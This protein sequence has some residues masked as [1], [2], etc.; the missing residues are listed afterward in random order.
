MAFLSLRIPIHKS[1]CLFAI[2]TE[3]GRKSK[4]MRV[5]V[6]CLEALPGWLHLSLRSP[7]QLPL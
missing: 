1:G 3:L 4:G 5:D 7:E 2:L 6:A